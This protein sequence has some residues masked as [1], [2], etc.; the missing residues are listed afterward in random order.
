MFEI[1]QWRKLVAALLDIKFWY[2]EEERDNKYGS[3]LLVME[4]SVLEKRRGKLAGE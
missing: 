4:I 1:Q 3:V 2:K